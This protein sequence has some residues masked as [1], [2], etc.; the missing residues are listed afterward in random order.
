MGLSLDMKGN[1]CR[2]DTQR[3]RD[4]FMSGGTD[5]IQRTVTFVC[6]SEDHQGKQVAMSA[7]A[8]QISPLR[9]IFIFQKVEMPPV[10]FLVATLQRNTTLDGGR[11]DLPHLTLTWRG[12]HIS[13][14]E[15]SGIPD[16]DRPQRAQWS[17]PIRQGRNDEESSVPSS[18]N[19]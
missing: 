18:K 3:V 16:L 19:L 6:K 12:A 1:A 5:I 9:N 11:K 4:V 14:L 15:R 2:L 13:Q 17:I 8:V 7:K 10:Q